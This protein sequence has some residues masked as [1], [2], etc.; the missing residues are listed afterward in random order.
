MKKEGN[1]VIK[2]AKLTK[3]FGNISAANQITFNVNSVTSK[4]ITD[5]EVLEAQK[6]F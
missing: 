6:H 2:A 3:R 1:K 5:E 4:V